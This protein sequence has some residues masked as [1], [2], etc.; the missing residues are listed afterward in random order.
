MKKTSV[1][2]AF[3]TMVILMSLVSFA[4]LASAA[5]GIDLP[6]LDNVNSGGGDAANLIVEELDKWV[7]TIRIIGVVLAVGGI[8]GGA[9]VFSLSLGNAQRR[10]LGVSAM[11]C[12]AMGIIV[13]AKADSIA[14]Y[15]LN[16]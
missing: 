1:K 16:S 11:V 4:G 2:I 15:F 12:A 14:G 9:I 3:L 8:V 6:D 13:M 7:G 5:G 10:G